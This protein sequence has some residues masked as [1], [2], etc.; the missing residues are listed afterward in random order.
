[1]ARFELIST[2]SIVIEDINIHVSE[3]CVKRN[4]LIYAIGMDNNY[5]DFNVDDLYKML[6]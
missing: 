6:I 4:C 1:M 3:I 5:L 2:D